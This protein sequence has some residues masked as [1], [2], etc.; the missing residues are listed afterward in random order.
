MFTASLM[1]VH[2]MKYHYL[3]LLLYMF[4]PIQAMAPNMTSNAKD[5]RRNKYN[6]I[7]QIR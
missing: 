7:P 1:M 6:L 2:L 3:V 5:K 4:T